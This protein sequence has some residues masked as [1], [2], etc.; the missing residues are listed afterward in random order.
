M[1]QLQQRL[2]RTSKSRF[3]ESSIPVFFEEKLYS[4]GRADKTDMLGKLL[5]DA[6][7]PAHICTETILVGTQLGRLTTLL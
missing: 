7:S 6:F 1:Q 5:Q 4:D 3:S 2:P